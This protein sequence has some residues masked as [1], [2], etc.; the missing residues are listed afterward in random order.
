MFHHLHDVCKSLKF[1]HFEC[2]FMIVFHF[3]S[4]ISFVS[5]DELAFILFFIILW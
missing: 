4:A 2:R 3:F 1:C 5:H